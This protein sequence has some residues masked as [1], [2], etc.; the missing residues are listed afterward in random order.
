MTLPVIDLLKFQLGRHVSNTYTNPSFETATGTTLPGIDPADGIQSDDWAAEGSHSLEVLTDRSVVLPV[1]DPST[2]KVVAESPG[3]VLLG[4][5]GVE[6]GRN[7]VKNPAL[8]TTSTGWSGS[9]IG[10][11][12]ATPDR[13]AGAGHGGSHGWRAT[14][15]GTLTPG[16]HGLQVGNST[17]DHVAVTAGET[18]DPSVYLHS[19]RASRFGLLLAFY[20]ADNTMVGPAVGGGAVAVPSN[21]QTRIAD[22]PGTTVPAT[23]VR[24]LI[25]VVPRTGTGYNAIVSG[26]VLTLSKATTA[27]GDYFDGSTLP[28]SLSGIPV[29]AGTPNASET[30]VYGVTSDTA[31]TAEETLTVEATGHLAMLE[32]RWDVLTVVEGEYGGEPFLTTNIDWTDWT[33]DAQSIRIARGGGITVDVGT[34]NA[35][36]IR[37]DDPLDEGDIRPGQPTRVI[38]VATSTPIFTGVVQDAD[39]GII[40]D[41]GGLTRN[42]VNIVAVDAV[43]SHVKNTR[44][45]AGD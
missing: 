26:D 10:S 43:A 4:S 16:A 2:V 25:R 30:I 34:L 7:A 24:M 17:V 21:T 35:A 41:N 11:V 20:A 37:D 3:Q 13:V 18:I 45:G 32:G 36:L 28:A 5:T 31:T 33:G 15:T 19:T 42:V 12:L 8:A 27:T 44:Y 9:G 6:V 23:A 38:D 14:A 40:R 29:W 22:L 1:A 39:I